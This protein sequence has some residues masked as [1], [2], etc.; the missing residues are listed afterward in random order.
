MM[1]SRV[2]VG[3]RAQQHADHHI[4]LRPRQ[5]LAQQLIAEA[6]QSLAHFIGEL[7]A[8]GVAAVAVADLGFFGDFADQAR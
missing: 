3:A 2:L 5:I 6:R 8:H 1:R 7:V 4:V